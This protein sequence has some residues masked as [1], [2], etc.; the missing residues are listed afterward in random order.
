M[1][2]LQVRHFSNKLKGKGK[3]KSEDD[4]AVD[5]DHQTLLSTFILNWI[6]HESD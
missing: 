5:L 2:L 6:D 3:E 4:D 1:F